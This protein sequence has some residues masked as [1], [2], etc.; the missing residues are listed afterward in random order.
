[1]FVRTHFVLNVTF[2]D[3]CH[4][5]CNET[6]AF[7]NRKLDAFCYYFLSHFVIEQLSHF[8]I[9]CYNEPNMKQ[10]Y[11]LSNIFTHLNVK[12]NLKWVVLYGCRWL[13]NLSTIQDG[14]F[15][16]CSRMRGRP[17]RLIVPKI[18]HTYPTMMTLGTIIPYLKKIQ[19][20][21]WITWRTP[22]VLL[23]SVFFSENQQILLNEKMQIS[24]A[25]W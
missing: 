4:I 23:A 13:T 20:N 6:V 12:Q 10:T 15:W 22:W 1:M 16:G 9:N 11:I 25:F 5:F 2:C 14:P 8:V 24:I 19:T 17:K 18:C 3:S 21:I 7:W